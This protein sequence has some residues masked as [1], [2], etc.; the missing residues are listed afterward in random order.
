MFVFYIENISYLIWKPCTYT[1]SPAVISKCLRIRAKDVTPAIQSSV[2]LVTFLR[3]D[4][5]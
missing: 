1:F 4:D 3:K 2:Y 5:M